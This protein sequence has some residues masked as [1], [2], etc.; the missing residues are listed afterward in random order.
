VIRGHLKA[1]RDVG[2]GHLL[3]QRIAEQSSSVFD[4]L[5]N[6]ATSVRPRRSLLRQRFNDGAESV[7]GEFLETHRVVTCAAS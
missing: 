1:S 2:D 7:E 4:T 5:A 6:E 3:G